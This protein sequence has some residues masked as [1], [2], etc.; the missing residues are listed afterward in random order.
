MVVGGPRSWSP[1]CVRCKVRSTRPSFLR[2]GPLKR[3]APDGQIPTHSHGIH[4]H[5]SHAPQQ[6]RGV[7]S[8]A[9][10]ILVGG[11]C[12]NS[13]AG[14]RDQWLDAGESD[15]HGKAKARPHMVL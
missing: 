8:S 15:G 12:G 1:Y 7:S 2:C 13:E 9:G 4:T 3:A 5:H 6:A 14:E 10:V 11:A